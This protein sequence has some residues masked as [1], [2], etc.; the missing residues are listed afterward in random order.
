MLKEFVYKELLDKVS[1]DISAGGALLIKY[2]YVVKI[3]DLD[4]L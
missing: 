1:A 2:G 4:L 3:E